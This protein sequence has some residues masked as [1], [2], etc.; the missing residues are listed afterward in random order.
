MDSKEK[1]TLKYIGKISEFNEVVRKLITNIELEDLEKSYLLGV[2]ILLI[3]NYQ[4][5]RRFTSYIDFAYYLILKYSLNTG[6][7]KP[8]YDI[9]NQ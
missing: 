5:D 3:K 7:Y 9:C 1:R 8:L 6:D 4:I 2:S